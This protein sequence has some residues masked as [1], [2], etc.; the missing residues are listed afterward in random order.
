MVRKYSLI[1][2]INIYNYI[3]SNYLFIKF[4]SDDTKTVWLD[5][6][7]K[8]SHIDAKSVEGWRNY[9][10][11]VSGSQTLVRGLNNNSHFS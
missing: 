10:E 2:C 3:N 9:V 5:D 11:L 1:I 4:I 8:E 6:N 7:D